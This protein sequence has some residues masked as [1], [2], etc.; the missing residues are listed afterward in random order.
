M[1]R[2]LWACWVN[3]EAYTAKGEG[4]HSEIAKYRYVKLPA[5]NVRGYVRGAVIEIDAGVETVEINPATMHPFEA[6]WTTER[7]ARFQPQ[8]DR[9]Y[10]FEDLPTRKQFDM[11]QAAMDADMGTPDKLRD[12]V[13]AAAK[14]YGEAE[15]AVV[16]GNEVALTTMRAYYHILAMATPSSDGHRTLM[17]AGVGVL[18]QEAGVRVLDVALG[19]RSNYNTE[20]AGVFQKWAELFS[21]RANR[22]PLWVN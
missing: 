7:G 22:V 14:L 2:P 8:G 13:L 11:A 6:R 10:A 4:S 17:M 12:W 5:S 16:Q 21:E 19:N 3:G 15:L 20:P 1:C 18:S 9:F